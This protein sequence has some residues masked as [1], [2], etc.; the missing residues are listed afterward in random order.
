[1]RVEQHGLGEFA[2]D[3]RIASA[4]I[5]D[6]VERITATALNNMKKDAQKRVRVRGKSIIKG[7]P[8][9]FNY[10]VAS[11]ASTVVGEVGADLTRPQGPLDH[12]IENGSPT[13]AP[14]PHWRPAA[15]KEVPVWIRFLDDV[16]VEGIDDGGR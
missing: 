2:D 13:S 10:D 5:V 8:R 11:L 6:R 12:I 15:D 14:I 9:S 4:G 1:M 7:L 3:L 16:A